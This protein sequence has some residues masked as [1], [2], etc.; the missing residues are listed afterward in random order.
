MRAGNAGEV[1]AAIKILWRAHKRG[2]AWALFYMCTIALLGQMGPMWRVLGV[3]VFPF[4]LMRGVLV[5][6]CDPL[7][8]RSFSYIQ[9]PKLPFFRQA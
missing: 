3:I 7:G 8:V 9:N 1:R 4:A 6:Q 2:H 5:L